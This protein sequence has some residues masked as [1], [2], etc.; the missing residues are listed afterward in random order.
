MASGKDVEGLQETS[1]WLLLRHFP[2]WLTRADKESLLTHFGAVEV[3]V[4]PTRGKMVCDFLAM[5]QTIYLF[6]DSLLQKHTVFAGFP[7]LGDATQVL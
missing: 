3:V 7:N 1:S 5:L 4:M 2:K 6:P